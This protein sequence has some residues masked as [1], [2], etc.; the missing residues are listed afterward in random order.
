MSVESSIG[1]T[2]FVSA[3]FP[4]AETVVAYELLTWTQ[5]GEVTDYGDIGSTTELLDHTP[6]ETGVT[7]KVYGVRNENGY[8]L[9]IAQDSGDAGQVILSTAYDARAFVSTKLVEVGGATEYS[10][11][12]IAGLPV[13]IGSA[14]NTKVISV[15]LM[16]SGA[17]VK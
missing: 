1:T 15:D 6:V 2:F 16:I 13:N 12:A 10:K 14:S 4:T 11:S 3:A 9:K 8:P 7:E 5:V 17:K